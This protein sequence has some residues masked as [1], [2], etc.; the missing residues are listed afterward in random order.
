M[1]LLGLIPM[2]TA[3]PA[4]TTDSKD[5]KIPL[6]VIAPLKLVALLLNLPLLSPT[7]SYTIIKAR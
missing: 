5:H 3:I 7:A 4:S 6:D 2:D 1:A